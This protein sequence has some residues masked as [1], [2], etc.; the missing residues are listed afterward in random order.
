LQAAENG[1][2]NLN[3][4]SINQQILFVLTLRAAA[5]HLHTGPQELTPI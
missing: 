4:K 3:G 2:K 1:S 5:E